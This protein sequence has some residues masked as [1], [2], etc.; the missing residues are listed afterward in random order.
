MI[1]FSGY[2]DHIFSFRETNT[3]YE[4]IG[5]FSDSDDIIDYKISKVLIKNFKIKMGDP[6]G[7][8]RIEFNKIIKHKQ[9]V[10]MREDFPRLDF[11][12]YEVDKTKFDGLENVYF[13]VDGMKSFFKVCK[14]ENNNLIE[15]TNID[16]KKLLPPHDFR[17]QFE[18]PYDILSY[19]GKRYIYTRFN[20]KRGIRQRLIFISDDN[21]WNFNRSTI[22]NLESTSGM[23]SDTI[24]HCQLV[25]KND[26]IYG[27][28]FGYDKEIN[29]ST[30]WK[31][32]DKEFMILCESD[33]GINFKE[34]KLLESVKNASYSMYIIGRSKNKLMYTNRRKLINVHKQYKD[35]LSPLNLSILNF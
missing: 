23:T 35:L 28:F 27:I 7:G 26:K 12:M 1:Y 30:Q 33:D 5:R 16:L 29:T 25:T 34:I 14:K 9:L 24:Y 2:P 21:S 4:F 20:L 3:H 17:N 18:S 15:L 31:V 19:K 8:T 6:K 22:L 11:T 13:V 10:K 32:R